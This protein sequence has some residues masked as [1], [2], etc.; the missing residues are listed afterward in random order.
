MRKPQPPRRK[1]S[2]ADRC[3]AEIA[4]ERLREIADDPTRAASG[5]KLKAKL[6]K[7]LE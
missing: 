5:E 1:I 6:K 2:N 7:L 3:D 4:A